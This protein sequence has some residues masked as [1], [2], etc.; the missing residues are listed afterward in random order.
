M[1]L[2]SPLPDSRV[3]SAAGYWLERNVECCLGK[4]WRNR[5]DP[6]STAMGGNGARLGRHSRMSRQNREVRTF[7]VQAVGK[8]QRTRSGNWYLR[9]E[10]DEG[11]TAFW[12]SD[13]NLENIRR[14][15][16]E[17]P[18]FTVTCRPISSNWTTH[19][20]WVPERSSVEVHALA[21]AHPA[22]VAVADSPRRTS[23]SSAT[24]EAR[25][26]LEADW[27]YAMELVAPDLRRL[28]RDLFERHSPVPVVGFELIGSAGVVLAEAELAW[29][30]KSVA[31]LLPEQWDSILEF[32][33]AG[34]HVF[35]GEMEDHF[36][37]LAAS[38]DA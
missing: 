24:R 31:V 30:E 26:R 9:C 2:Q 32:E 19:D 28:V 23:P 6:A 29:P 22:R 15:E 16:A 27:M 8:P 7:E 17:R 14:V 21:K 18:P 36:D 38:L 20:A 33:N 13:G 12:G 25:P 11:V 5:M 10:T 35:C 3:R 34:W 4:S 37:A 1:T